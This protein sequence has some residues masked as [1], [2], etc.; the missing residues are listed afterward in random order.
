MA[1]NLLPAPTFTLPTLYPFTSTIC[2]Q[3]PWVITL[4][5]REASKLFSFWD[6][7]VDITTS[8]R[9]RLLTARSEMQ[10][11]CGGRSS[12]MRFRQLCPASL[13]LRQV[14]SEPFASRLQLL[15]RPQLSSTS[16]SQLRSISLA[17]LP[18]A[19]HRPHIN[20]HNIHKDPPI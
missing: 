12:S 10:S 14:I 5:W 1:P 7:L 17:S 9:L 6:M 18:S 3:K 13:L 19:A 11:K 16:L 8:T 2:F 20:S 4:F 15:S